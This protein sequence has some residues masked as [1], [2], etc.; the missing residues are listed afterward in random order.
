MFC[1]NCGRQLN[2]GE[3][4]TCTGAQ[5]PHVSPFRPAPAFPGSAPAPTPEPAFS[6]PVMSP[7]P[8]P[9]FS[10]SAQ[11][12]APEP[13]FSESAQAP[14]SA[15]VFSEPAQA[16]AP[17]P[18]FSES[19]QAPAPVMPQAAFSQAPAPTAYQAPKAPVTGHTAATRD[20]ALAALGSPFV[21]VFGLVTLAK[22]IFD[23]V[24]TLQGQNGINL[25][26]VIP[27]HFV[28]GSG[29]TMSLYIS[30]AFSVLPLFISVASIV[31]FCTA[32]YAKATGKPFSTIGPT[33]ASAFCIAKLTLIIRL[34]LII[35]F[36]FVSIAA[37]TG[38]AELY[39]GLIVSGLLL[40]YGFLYY[41][42]ISRA[43]RGIRNMATGQGKHFR[44][45]ILPLIS[46]VFAIFAHILVPFLYR[47]LTNE[48]KN[49]GANITREI[50]TN[51]IIYNIIR[52]P[53]RY[54]IPEIVSPIK[55]T[56]NNVTTPI[57]DVI[58]DATAFNNSAF[59]TLMISSII[60]IVAILIGAVA[61]IMARR[62]QNTVE[63]DL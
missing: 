7:A 15:P 28:L 48:I 44:V 26:G 39:T 36:I 20:A 5:A 49:L 6:E 1:E 43:V 10:E 24:T 52:L 51:N 31:T 9:V 11:A 33:L 19:A 46:M 34:A 41:F 57:K 59:N 60:S 4:C 16:P 29:T 54:N 18:I 61:L 2:E 21:L 56:I 3:V 50:S 45:S 8:E 14:A 23:L 35:G 13:V 40:L 17:E 62:A 42:F 53:D 12:P 38:Y 37:V 27:S 30:V 32:K 22:V 55:N 63:R 47:S 58:K 25:I